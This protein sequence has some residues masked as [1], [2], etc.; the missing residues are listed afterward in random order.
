MREEYKE[1]DEP[2]GEVRLEDCRRLVT[3]TEGE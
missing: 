2:Y 1:R 3:D